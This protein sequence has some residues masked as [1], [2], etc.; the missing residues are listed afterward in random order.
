MYLSAMMN[1]LLAII[2]LLT[3][4]ACQKEDLPPEEEKEE[5]NEPVSGNGVVYNV[6]TAVM[7]NLINEARTKGCTCG[8][9][10][11]PP[12]PA[13]K[14]NDKLSK[15]A[16][17]HSSDMNA[18]NYFSHTGLNGTDPGQRITAQGFTWAAYGENIARG[19]RSEA[20]V[21]DGWLKS[22]GHCKN[23]M[24]GSFTHVGAGK[25]GNYWTQNFG[26]P[27]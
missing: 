5:I 21:M 4:A 13:V 3:L 11:M 26:K 7:L 19:Q 8:S 12:V 23:I 14:W 9:T 17:L 15:A 16:Y 25:S 27:R 20:E 1:K 10:V 22:E 6:N 2:A 24:N 18:N